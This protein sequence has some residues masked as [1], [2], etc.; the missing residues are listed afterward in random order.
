MPMADRCRLAHVLR[1]FCAHQD[2]DF[3]FGLFWPPLAAGP[4]SG[5]PSMASWSEGAGLDGLR[6][7][8]LIVENLNM[9]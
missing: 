7:E 9:W 6:T 4:V 8:P 1:A 2:G 5:A 3:A